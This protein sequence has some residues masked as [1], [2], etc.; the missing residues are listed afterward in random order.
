MP[1]LPLTTTHQFLSFHFPSNSSSHYEKK[2][3]FRGG[4]KASLLDPNEMF[5]LQR[6]GAAKRSAW[7][8]SIAEKA[9]IR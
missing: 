5:P 4:G 8:E 7:Q 9:E 6:N 1:T 2:E 3:P